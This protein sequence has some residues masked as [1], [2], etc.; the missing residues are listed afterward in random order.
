MRPASRWLHIA[1]IAPPWF[2]IPPSSYGG[3]ELVVAGLVDS[4]VAAG[5]QVTLVGAGQHRTRA[6]RFLQTLPAPPSTE[7][8][9][10]DL[11]PELVH[12]ARAA[13]LL[14][15]LSPDVVHD[16]SMAGPLL[17][18]ERSV[19]T[20]VTVHGHVTDELRSYYQS[21]SRSV[22]LVAVSDSQ[23]RQA[24]ALPWGHTVHNGVK[25]ADFPFLSRKEEFVLYVGRIHKNKGVHLAIEAAAAAGRPIVLAG[26]CSE[27][28]EREYFEQEIAPR[29]GPR[30][31]W[32]G[33]VDAKSK[34]ALYSGAHCLIF[35]VCWEEPFGLV[36]I[37]AMACGTPVVALDRG[38]VP[39]IVD[40]GITGVV[41]NGPDSLPRAIGLAG[42]LKPHVC[43]RQVHQRFDTGI[44]TATYERVY[45]EVLER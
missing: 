1:I 17:A 5:H 16:H 40:N 31:R 18:L 12:A 6:Q 35:P 4:L 27:P 19:P 28:A 41:C 10:N 42:S 32:V 37:E 34:N 38:A 11:I 9:T 25:V 24:P 7:R 30:V 15:S 29:L 39:E 44:M 45:R 8:L 3:I 43:R 2:E 23:R 33:E 14:T 26:R 21:L 36:M 13:E 20:V 22:L